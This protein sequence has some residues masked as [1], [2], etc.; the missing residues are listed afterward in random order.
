MNTFQSKLRLFFVPLAAVV[1]FGL[2]GVGVWYMRTETKPKVYVSP[3][4][5]KEV[6][7]AYRK[8][9]RT[10]LDG[11]A[12]VPS[13]DEQIKKVTDTLQ[14]MRVPKE[15]RDTHLKVFLLFTNDP[16]AG[17]ESCAIQVNERLAPLFASPQL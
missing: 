14:V 8:E 13:C 10:L 15:N 1:V 7:D 6:G 5:P 16:L 3:T 9:L 2:F 17:K 12:Q 11:M 4:S